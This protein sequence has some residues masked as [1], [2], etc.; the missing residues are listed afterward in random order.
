MKNRLLPLFALALVSAGAN[1]QS[2]TAPTVKTAELEAIAGDSVMVYNVETKQ[3]WNQGNAWGTQLSVADDGLLFKFEYHEN[4][5]DLRA[6]GWTILTVSGG[7]A[8]N[9]TFRADG[10]G[11]YVDMGSQGH[12][13]WDI[14]KTEQGYYRIRTIEADDVY[15]L[16]RRA[17]GSEEEGD[18]YDPYV[19]EWLGIQLGTTVV[20]PGANLDNPETYGAFD[21]Q[22]VTPEDFDAYQAAKTLYDVLN[23]AAELGVDTEAASA[24]YQNPNATIEEVEAATGELRSAIMRAGASEENPLDVT[25]MLKNPTFEGSTGGWEIEMPNNHA[26]GGGYQTAKYQNGEIVI[27]KFIECWTW[28]VGSSGADSQLGDGHIQQTMK[29]L[30]QGKYKLTVDCISVNQ[31]FEDGN[32]V[33]GVQLFATGGEVDTNQ[34]IATGNG[35]PEHFEVIFY[36]TGGDVTMGLRCINSNANWIAADNFTLTYY[37]EVEIDPWKITLDNAIA[38]FEEKYPDLDAVHAYGDTK[39]AFEETLE[40]VRAAE[41]DYQGAYNKLNAAAEELASSIAF[42]NNAKGQI[43]YIDKRQNEINEHGW[44]DLASEIADIYDELN[45]KYEDEVLVAEDLEGVLDTIRGM[46]SAYASEHVKPGDNVTILL[47]NAGFDINFSGWDVTG[48]SPVWGASTGQGA[49]HT[50]PYNVQE[51]TGGLAERYHAVFSMS[52]TIKNMPA[53]MYELSCQAFNRK[54]GEGNP[55]E[56]YAILPDGTSQVAAVPDIDDYATDERLYESQNGEGN[57]EW[58]SDAERN[59][60]WAPN[61]MSGSAWHFNYKSDP[62]SE[63]NDYTVKFQIVMAETGDL[64]MGVRCDNDQQWVIF[65]NFQIVYKGAGVGTFDGLI[66]KLIAEVNTTMEQA[67]SGYAGDVLEAAVSAMEAGENAKAVSDEEEYKTACAAAIADLNKAIADLKE[68]AALAE[69]LASKYEIIGEYLIQEVESSDANFS[70]VLDEVG[71]RIEAQDYENNAEIEALYVKLCSGWTAYIQYDELTATEAEPGDISEVIYN[72]SGVDPITSDASAEGW[73]AVGNVGVDGRSFEQFN[74]KESDFHQDIYGLAPGYYR[75]KV[76]GFYRAGLGSALADSIK[77]GVP[78]DINAVLY[79]NNDSTLMA[80]IMRDIEA[81]SDT[82]QAGV[83]LEMDEKKLYLIDSMAQFAA[84]LDIADENGNPTLYNNCL[85]FKVEEGQEKT[86]IGIKRTGSVI[87]DWLIFSNWQLEYVGTTEPA[88]DPTTAV[89]G[90]ES[91]APV[92]TTRIYNIDGQQISR[93]KKGV[94]IIKTT[95]S[96]GTVRIQKVLVR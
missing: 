64:T 49:N 60:K 27:E 35:K 17:I 22:F 36:S 15:G 54:D 5:E 23:E 63:Y 86:T 76:Q 85:Q 48:S 57:P 73:E 74:L 45:S 38:G 41:E 44:E 20:D 62:E 58:W 79:A 78:H 10:N 68:S 80:D 55:A 92:Q 82:L 70:V 6:T 72:R 39:K 56:L 19:G 1:A 88:E 25:Y 7:K 75:V 31:Y 61:G 42:Y 96:D 83:V 91:N 81:Y 40:E 11:A 18:Y 16:G 29:N 24:V 9:Y 13:Y 37:G 87:N 43:D 71:A 93:M 50:N 69:K 8:G 46:I 65:D 2:W 3:F 14:Q 21:W 66:D 53:G 30:P 33:K 52:Q 90:I 12:Q 94:N 77:A 26:G 84:A 51:P 47:E 32:P 67:V 34:S 95:L 59:G 4:A 89:E 28:N